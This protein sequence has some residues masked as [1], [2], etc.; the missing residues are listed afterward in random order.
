MTSPGDLPPTPTPAA[1]RTGK[2]NLLDLRWILALLFGFYGTVLTI[3]G[4]AFT[5]A[6][7]R[8]LAGGVNVNLWAGIGMLL[9]AAAFAAW[10]QWRPVPLP[11]STIRPGPS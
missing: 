6:A 1:G 9:L 5:S 2:A 7:D 8:Q 11:E 4:A 3:L 10:A